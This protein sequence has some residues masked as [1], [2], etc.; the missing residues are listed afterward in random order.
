MPSFEIDIPDLPLQ[1][2]EL[3]EQVPAGRVTTYGDLAEALGDVA[4]ARWVG[5]YLLD[6]PHDGDCP[7]HRVVRRTG[8]LG[9][10]ITGDEA[11]KQRRLTADGVPVSDGAEWI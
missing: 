9:L 8:E 3:L 2:R 6:H 10:F 5:S 11:D 1:L 4:A 7:C